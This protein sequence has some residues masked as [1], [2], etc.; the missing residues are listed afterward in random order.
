MG[1]LNIALRRAASPLRTPAYSRARYTAYQS[2]SP[3]GRRTSCRGGSRTAPTTPDDVRGA[4]AAMRT[5]VHAVVSG[6]G[7]AVPLLG[8]P[9]QPDAAAASNSTTVTPAPPSCGPAS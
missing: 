2:T 7:T 5:H 3:H 6:H 8:K 4:K 9:L 1:G